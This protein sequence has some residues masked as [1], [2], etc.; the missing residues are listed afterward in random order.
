MKTKKNSIEWL[1]DQ[2]YKTYNN[3]TDKKLNIKKIINQA[4]EMYREEM[5]QS[6]RQGWWFCEKLGFDKIEDKDSK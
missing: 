1:A 5:I 3:T 2:L 4:N 6:Y